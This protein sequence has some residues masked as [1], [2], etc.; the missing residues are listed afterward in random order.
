MGKI[1]TIAENKCCEG[2]QHVIS[3]ESKYCSCD[4]TFGIYIPEK[5]SSS[6]LPL[7]WFLSGLTCT[8][9][10]AM[11]KSGI[12]R[13]AAEKKIAVVFPDTSPRGE[14][15]PDDSNFD[16]GQG[17]GFYV[18]SKKPPWEKN[19]QM[20]SYIQ[21]ELPELI[22]SNFPLDENKQSIMGHSMGGLGALN[23]AFRNPNTYKAVSAFAPIS[24]PTAGIWGR[25]QFEAYLGAESEL[26]EEYDPSILLKKRGYSGQILIDQGTK[27][28]FLENLM[29]QSLEKHVNAREQGNSFRYQEGYDHSYFFVSTFIK[30]HVFWHEKILNK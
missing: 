24:N 25:K 22:F 23:I 3:H 18:D 14:G 12:Q 9:E 20:W 10:N 1:T 7:I 2:M 17:A 16:L 29:P 6:E 15:V 27:D 4:M 8:H 19:F 26:W 21:K 28:D 30:D 5:A 13:W 11:V